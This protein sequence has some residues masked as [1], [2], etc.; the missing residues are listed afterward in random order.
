MTRERGNLGFLITMADAV[1]YLGYVIII[2]AKNSLSITG[3]VFGYFLT[4]SWIFA[5][6]SLLM[7]IPC[8]RYFAR[9]TATSPKIE[10][11]V[12]ET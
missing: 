9:Q 5:G 2:V 4:L 3:D 10:P 7:L 1:G 11:T 12:V 6:A 8:W